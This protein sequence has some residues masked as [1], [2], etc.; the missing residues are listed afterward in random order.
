MSP[1]LD[2]SL[3]KRS[4]E[5]LKINQDWKSRV[6][7]RELGLCWRERKRDAAQFAF[8]NG[9]TRGSSKEINSSCGYVDALAYRHTPPNSKLNR[10]V[11]C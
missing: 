9:K 4:I 10:L 5:Q 11:C 1:R 6:N 8:Q 3:R 2:F 7:S